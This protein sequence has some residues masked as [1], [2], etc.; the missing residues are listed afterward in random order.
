MSLVG[1]CKDSIGS[2][3]RP[4]VQVLTIIEDNLLISY[5]EIIDQRFVMYSDVLCIISDLRVDI[6]CYYLTYIAY[7]DDLSLLFKLVLLC[8]QPSSL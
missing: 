6:G 8:G 3:L 5:E 1:P 7:T 2:P 4:L